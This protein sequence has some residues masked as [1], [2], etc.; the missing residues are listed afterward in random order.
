V[1]LSEP[2]TYG[3]SPV[4]PMVNTPLQ[5]V[6]RHYENQTR[7]NVRV[8]DMCIGYLRF[9]YELAFL[10]KNRTSK[11]NNTPHFEIQISKIVW[12]RQP[13]HWGGDTPLF[14]AYGDSV[15]A[16][17]TVKKFSFKTCEL[18]YNSRSFS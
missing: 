16:F 6:R 7:K 5:V 4:R 15:L 2:W 1:G 3:S 10:H 17:C 12:V 8:H 14:G 13:L 18:V 9:S 11:C